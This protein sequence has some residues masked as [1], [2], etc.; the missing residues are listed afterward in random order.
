MSRRNQPAVHENVGHP[1]RRA[2]CLLLAA[3]LV[4][5][6]TPLPLSARLEKHSEVCSTYPDRVIDE[7]ALHQIGRAHV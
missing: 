2:L 7:L 4:A 5:V 3:L 1:C 6:S